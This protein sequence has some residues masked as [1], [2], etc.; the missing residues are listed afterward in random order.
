MP[1]CPYC[2]VNLQLSMSEKEA[3]NFLRVL[4]VFY[5]TSCR[6]TLGMIPADYASE[7]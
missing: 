1:K 2:G 6:A 5:R 3:I 7:K 4:F